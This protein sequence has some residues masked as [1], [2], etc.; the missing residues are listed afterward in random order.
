MTGIVLE[1]SVVV[2]V[3][4]IARVDS[5]RSAQVLATAIRVVDEVSI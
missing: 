3:N 1:R 2:S 4:S 5:E